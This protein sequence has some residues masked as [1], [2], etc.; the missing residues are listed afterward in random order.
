MLLF[1]QVGHAV[2]HGGMPVAVGHVLGIITGGHG[3]HIL[4]GPGPELGDAVDFHGAG[5]GRQDELRA[6]EHEDAGA[7]RE[8][9]VI[10]D[11]GAHLHRACGGVQ[12]RH[13]EAVPGGEMALHIEVA[14]VHLG[15]G[16][17]QCAEAVEEEQG[18]AGAALVPLQ[19]GEG[20][21]H[22]QLPGQGLEGADEAAAGGDG[23]GGPF[24]HG[25]AVDL[26][27]AAPHLGEQGDVGPQVLGL[28]TGG[29]PLFQVFLQ[30]GTGGDLQ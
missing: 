21:G 13:M 12:L 6:L 23:P 10:A 17:P 24:L 1:R 18:I 20:D 26:V 2:E 9:P 8:L 28:F 14:G 3:Q 7:L 19:Q 15:V 29:Q 30:G 22:G 11:H 25:A 16:K 5:V 4:K 27:A